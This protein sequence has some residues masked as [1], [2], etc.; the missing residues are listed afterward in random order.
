MEERLQ[1][2]DAE[3]NET[4]SSGTKIFLYLVKGML[5]YFK[6]LRFGEVGVF[7]DRPPF[8][9]R[10]NNSFHFIWRE[11]INMHGICPR[12]LSVLRSEQFSES[13]A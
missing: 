9:K 4:E 10:N 12:S 3:G 13:V 1:H 2:V 11:N 5:I 7:F 8:Y 6:I